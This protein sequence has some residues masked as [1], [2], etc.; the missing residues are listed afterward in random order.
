MLIVGDVGNK[1]FALTGRVSAVGVENITTD[2]TGAAINRKIFI[3]HLHNEHSQYT[4]NGDHNKLEFP[5]TKNTQ[6]P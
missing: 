1:Y 3:I 2:V 4:C 6:V 5:R